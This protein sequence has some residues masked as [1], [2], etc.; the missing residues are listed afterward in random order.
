MYVLCCAC[1]KNL[2]GPIKASLKGIYAWKPRMR[3]FFFEQRDK[4]VQLTG[5]GWVIGEHLL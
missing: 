4:I 3:V 1:P 2:F 5:T